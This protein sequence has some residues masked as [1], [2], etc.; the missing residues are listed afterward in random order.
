MP[1]RQHHAHKTKCR[2]ALD[3]MDAAPFPLHFT[4]EYFVLFTN[5][6]VNAWRSNSRSRRDAT[7]KEFP[8]AQMGKV[9]FQELGI[10]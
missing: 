2:C 7:G 9:T 6:G 5:R 8:S 1:G 3:C 10:G 4:G